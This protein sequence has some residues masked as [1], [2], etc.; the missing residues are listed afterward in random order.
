MVCI[1]RP[2]SGLNDEN[3]LPYEENQTEV[4]IQKS[5]PKG[6]GK[7]G[8]FSLFYDVKGHSFYEVTPYGEVRYSNR[9][10][11]SIAPEKKFEEII[12][13]ENGY[14]SFWD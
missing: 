3:G 1:W 11:E 13:N 14:P 8:K 5:K 4:R 9:I 12:I 2:P 10:K 7:L 6:V